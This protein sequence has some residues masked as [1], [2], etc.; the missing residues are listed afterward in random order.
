MDA[1]AFLATCQPDQASVRDIP[2][3][4]NELKLDVAQRKV[5]V[6]RQSLEGVS[7]SGWQD[8]AQ[9]LPGKAQIFS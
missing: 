3:T 6:L 9:L 7:Q 2:A 4:I 8:A 1:T 5:E